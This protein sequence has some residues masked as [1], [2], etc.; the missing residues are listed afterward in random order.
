MIKPHIYIYIYTAHSSAHIKKYGP[1]I[2]YIYIYI[3]RI[4]RRI[5]VLHAIFF[6][7]FKQYVEKPLT[8]V[9]GQLSAHSRHI[10]R[11]RSRRAGAAGP[12]QPWLWKGPEYSKT[13]QFCPK[14][15]LALERLQKCPKRSS[16]EQKRPWPRRGPK[17]LQGGPVLFRKR[18]KDLQKPI[19]FSRKKHSVGKPIEKRS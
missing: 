5:S 12:E 9:V 19:K 18:S 2:A 1:G 15:V 11:K 7:I 16:S 6:D 4:S 10:F 3:R 17:M 8:V 13:E 14:T